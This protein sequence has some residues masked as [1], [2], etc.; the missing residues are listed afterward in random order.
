VYVEE[1]LAR[2]VVALLR[3]TRSD[4][5]LQLGG[6]PRAGIVLLRMA[7]A[8]AL[9]EGRDFL[10]PDDVKAVAAPVLAHRLILS[11]EAR[12][13]G[14]TEEDLVADALARTPVPV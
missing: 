6:S 3:Y 14:T 13:S 5:R 9:S 10:T 12:S 8:L 2:Y 1:S 4:S 7:K 11:A